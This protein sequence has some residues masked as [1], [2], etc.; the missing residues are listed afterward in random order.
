MDRVLKPF[1]A[2]LTG[3][4]AAALAALAAQPAWA[5]G[6]PGRGKD[7]FTAQCSSCHGVKSGQTVLGPSLFGVVG[8]RSASV[9]GFAY[10]KGMKAAGLTWTPDRIAAYIAAPKAVVPGDKMAFVGLQNPAQAA[11]LIAYLATLR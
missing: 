10:S 11:D 8:R 2:L 6:D 3:L 7:V 5:A 9:P 1:P 4:L